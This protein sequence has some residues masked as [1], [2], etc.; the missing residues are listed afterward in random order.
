MKKLTLIIAAAALLLLSSCGL[1]NGNDKPS[2]PA[3]P[4]VSASPSE[5]AVSPPAEFKSVE[6]YFPFK[7]NVHMT[8]RGEGNEFADFESFVEYIDNGAIQIRVRNPGTESVNVY[9]IEEG[10]VVNVF[11]EG[12]TY[13][14]Q[15]LTAERGRDEIVLMEP[16]E[17]GTSWKLP[18]GSVRTITAID[19]KVNVPYGKFEA[20]EV[21]TDAE[22]GVMKEYY[23]KDIGLIKRE[24]T[25]SEDSEFVVTSELESV[26]TDAP[27][28]VT[29]RFYYPDL[30]NDRTVFIDKSIELYTG[31]DMKDKLEY[32]LKHVPES[33][34][35]TPVMPE[36][37]SLLGIDF[38]RETRVVTIDFSKEFITEMNAGSRLE[39]LILTSVANTFG[40]YY[41]TDQ[42]AITI[43]G[44]PY[45]SGHFLFMSGDLVKVDTEGAV[46]YQG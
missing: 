23:A 44:G 36:G 41:Q 14:R 26:E 28:E 13:Y 16:I 29:V 27:L 4:T 1:L 2:P 9:I 30:D 10:A 19:A 22:G 5:P 25:S 39:G 35:L 18:D 11:S 40:G 42:V 32:E 7:E 45:E 38:N 3:E 17:I 8:Y 43:E 46:E 34:G 15:N 37:A 20:V 12:E 24:F 6:D 33:S 21:T 31:D